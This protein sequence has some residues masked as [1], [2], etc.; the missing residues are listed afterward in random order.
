MQLC[1]SGDK[2]NF[3]HMNT[4]QVFRLISSYRIH[5]SRALACLFCLLFLVGLMHGA[6]TRARSQSVRNSLANYRPPQGASDVRGLDD[7]KPI[8]RELSGGESHTYQL[9]VATGQYARVIVDQKG[10]DVVVSLF[11]PD[12]KLITA[13]DNPNGS[14]GAETVHITAEATGIYRLEV[15]SFEKAAHPGLYQAKLE[16]LRQA[17]QADRDRLTARRDFD[18]AERLVS[19]RTRDS[20]TAA[21][22]KYEEALAIYRVIDDQIEQFTVLIGI[23]NTSTRIN[24]SAKALECFGQALRIAQSLGDKFRQARALERTANVYN[25]AGELENGLRSSDEA[26][27]LYQATGDTRNEAH[28]LRSIG[29]IY[30]NLGE[31]EKAREYFERVVKLLQI[32]GDKE[33]EADALESIGYSYHLQGDP[34][35]TL[36]YCTRGLAIWRD[37]KNKEE[38]ARSLSFISG[39]F[40]RLGDRQKALTTAQQALNLTNSS[41][42]DKK[43][44]ATTLVNVGQTYYK[45]GDLEKALTFYDEPLRIYQTAGNKRNE[46]II[47][48]HIATAL[49]DLGRLEEAKVNIEKSIALMEFIREHAGSVGQ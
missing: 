5:E 45:L 11:G 10:I 47:L 19:L 46:A 13:V 48:K 36:E 43:A 42:L 20:L 33:G 18:E 12:G 4:Q 15:T 23:G 26:L 25:T 28:M 21:V 32:L 30:N 34:Q 44:S 14:Q 2:D 9:N 8:E 16:E 37:I 40:A 27:Q 24:D 38:E 39:E 41:N 7:G 49:R 29:F 17:T 35:K 22:K 1:S 31:L 3:I 6:R